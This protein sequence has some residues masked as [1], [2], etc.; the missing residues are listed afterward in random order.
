M[1]CRKPIYHLKFK[2]YFTAT[3]SN[4]KEREEENGKIYKKKHFVV[5]LNCIIFGSGAKQ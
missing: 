1:N 5:N 3:T 2:S 4:K